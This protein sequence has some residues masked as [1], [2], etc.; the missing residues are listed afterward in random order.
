MPDH[1]GLCHFKNS[2]SSV[3]P[4]TGTEHK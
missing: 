2:I 3:S 1:P 4:W